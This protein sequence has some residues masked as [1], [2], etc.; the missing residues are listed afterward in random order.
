MTTRKLVAE[1]TGPITINAE[2]FGHGSLVTVRAE[3]DCTRATLTIHTADESGASADAVKDATLRQSGNR[4]EAIVQGRGGNSGSTIVVGGGSSVIQSFGNVTGS[5]TGMTI[6]GNGTYISGGGGG[7]IIVNGVRISGGG[8]VVQGGSP[9]EITAV[10]PEGS[11]VEGY[12]QS[13]NILVVGA[14]RN[15][16]AKTQS[17][18]VQAGH[19]F[20]VEAKTQSGS[21]TVEQAAEIEAK[22]QSGR[23][24][25][26]RT[27]VVTAKTMSGSILIQDF[28]GTAQ[29]DT[30]S[31]SVHIHATAGGNVRAKTMS[32]SITVTA[33][34][35]ALA[36]DLDVQA[37]S[38]SG[39]VSIPQ[40]PSRQTGPRRR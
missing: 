26:G 28:G 15:V 27:D 30:M 24:R 22:T 8:T 38:M 39:H 31:G 18:S 11:S 32:G 23:I 29:A 34:E 25:L 10:V 13:A 1:T 19:A 20:R 17:G 6:T 33:T 4:L 21:I 5:V 14:V 12:T 2:L 16:Y 3:A 9:I 36:D 35:N 40:R 7:D 37:N